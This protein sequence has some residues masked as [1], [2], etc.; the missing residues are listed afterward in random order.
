MKKIDAETRR[1]ALKDDYKN[2]GK[3]DRNWYIIDSTELEEEFKIKSFTPEA[4]SVFIALLERWEDP[5]FFLEIFV[6]YNIGPDNHAFLCLDKMYGEICPICAIRDELQKAG[7][8]DDIYNVYRYTKRY[9]M[10]VVNA[11]SPRT[12]KDGV[13]LYD[14]PST[15]KNGILDACL[16]QRSGDIIDPSDPKEKVN[17]VFK[18][19]GKKGSL[20]TEYK[21]F[22][23]E[24]RED[25]IPEDYYELPE[26]NKLL[27]EPEL[28]EIKKVL[29]LAT[30]KERDTEEDT[31]K[32]GRGRAE[33]EEE[34]EEKS[35]R[36]FH[37]RGDDEE[38]KK[39][40]RLKPR[41]RF[42]DD[43]DEED[44]FDP[45]RFNKSRGDKDEDNDSEEEEKKEI[46]D[47]TKRRLRNRD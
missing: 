47:R 18:R 3:S 26:M 12:I 37:K 43:N 4:G 14:A 38:D 36:R 17:I 29:G 31:D 1:Q 8:P 10:W 39:P 20:R 44:P 27:R 35:E 32:R 7:E 46:L 22:S 34:T 45:K 13:M 23:I 15:V 41:D 25:K 11:E 9:L 24:N 6:H 30:R 40:R 19:I 28:S 2:R 21:A 5:K 16:D 42:E 33:R